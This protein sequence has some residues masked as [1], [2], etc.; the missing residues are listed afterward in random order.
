MSDQSGAVL[1]GTGVDEPAGAHLLPNSVARRSHHR[2]GFISADRHY[3]HV[4][5]DRS[6]RL[7]IAPGGVKMGRA[8]GWMVRKANPACACHGRD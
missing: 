1:V 4:D 8:I 2:G 6:A 5:S 7:P 3:R